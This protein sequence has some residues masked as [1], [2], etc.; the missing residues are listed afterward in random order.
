MSSKNKRN[1]KRPPGGEIQP[2]PKASAATG[3]RSPEPRFLPPPGELEALKAVQPD[4]PDR[5]LRY[6]EAQQA[7]E[8]GVTNRQIDQGDRIL[9]VQTKQ[10]LRGQMGLLFIGGIA[11]IG[12]LILIYADKSP[13]LGRTAFGVG[14][15]FAAFELVN[16][17]VDLFKR[18]GGKPAA[19]HSKRGNAR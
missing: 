9:A 15:L 14:V 6:C 13:Q 7:H 11:V 16:R 12:G 8:H 3:A 4:F 2:S 5:L 17:M 10:V 1:A 19:P 18:L